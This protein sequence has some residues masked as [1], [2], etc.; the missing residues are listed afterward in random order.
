MPRRD[1]KKRKRT[2]KTK[3]STEE[4]LMLLKKLK[5][6]TSQNVR[7]TVGD[8]KGGKSSYTPPFVVPQQQPSVSYTFA[9]QPLS[10]LAT[11][12]QNQIAPPPPPIAEPTVVPIVPRKPAIRKPK[13]VVT[14]ATPVTDTEPDDTFNL[15]SRKTFK[16]PPQNKS[17]N[18]SGNVSAYSRLQPSSQYTQY[19]TF[20][21]SREDNDNYG[22]EPASLPQDLWVG[23]P[24]G[25]SPAYQEM[26][27]KQAPTNESG[28]YVVPSPEEAFADEGEGEQEWDEAA[29][30]GGQL[31]ATSIVPGV[32]EPQVLTTPKRT[33]PKKTETPLSDVFISTPT[34]KRAFI[35]QYIERNNR[36]TPIPKQFLVSIGATRKG[37]L[38]KAISDRDIDNI[39][40]LAKQEIINM[41]QI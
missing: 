3:L 15:Y 37:T 4:I 21:L 12:T 20:D 39:Y 11:P 16:E 18:L 26:I 24:D 10:A 6:K 1:K 41:N 36:V 2:K 31:E 28:G 27:Q 40:Q 17:G 13:R 5:P 33:T 8:S 30:G 38:K 7:V 34:Q 9:G 32:A 23:S 19:P 35:E 14:I 22:T 25:A 29:G